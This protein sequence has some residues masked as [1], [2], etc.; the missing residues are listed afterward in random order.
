V[1]ACK[2][3]TKRYQVSAR[4]FLVTSTL[5]GQELASDLLAATHINHPTDKLNESVKTR[6]GTKG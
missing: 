3:D 6:G 1:D 5:P 4:C 2:T